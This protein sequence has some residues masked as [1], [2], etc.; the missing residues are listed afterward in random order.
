MKRF[1]FEG[2]ISGGMRL[3]VLLVLSP[4]FS[5]GCVERLLQIRSEPSGAEVYVNGERVGTTPLDHNFDYYGTFDIVL[6]SDEH[7]SLHRMETVHPPWYEITPIDFFT[8]NLLPVVI[9]DH[10][11]LHYVLEPVGENLDPTGERAAISERIGE[12]EEKLS[13]SKNQE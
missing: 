5:G 4:G 7:L 8:E 1:R 10:H 2:K 9:R 13:A 6:R 3:A 11:E 12:M